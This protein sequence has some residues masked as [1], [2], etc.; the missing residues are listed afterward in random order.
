MQEFIRVYWPLA[1]ITLL[2]VL[3]ALMFVDPGPPRRVA[4]AGGASGGAYAGAAAGYAAALEDK[5]IEAEV[6]TTAGS[7]E[8]LRRLAAGEADIAVVQTGTAEGADTAALRSIGAVFYEPLWVFHRASLSPDDLEDLRGRRVAVGV[9]GS[10]QR[11]LADRLL[12]EEGLGPADYT[13]V[14]LGGAAAAA[15]LK[16]GEIDAALIVS[17]AEPPWIADLVAAPGVELMSMTAAPGLARRNPFL[18]E[19]MLYEGVLD[20]ARDL[21]RRDTT[22]L[23]PA[24]EIVVRA[25]LHPA[26]QS[27]LIEAAYQ[28]HARGTMLAEAGTFPTPDLTDIPLSGE[29]QRYYRNGP[30]F[31]RRYFPYDIA[32]FL[33]RAWVLAIPLVTLMFPLA[34]V[35]PPVYRWRIRRRI[36]IWYRDLRRLEAEGR[37]ARSPEERAAV[38]AKLR[39]LQAEAGEV[40]VPLSYTDNLFHL[41]QHIKFVTD[42]MERLSAQDASAP[43]KPAAQTAAA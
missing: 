5:G 14:E 28:V 43:A 35:A 22:L 36:Y 33:E 6:L 30:T 21:P 42:L 10:G 4:I 9:D 39:E 37:A 23:A 26:V 16:A 31:L 3:A 27:L 18:A 41:R 12:A 34:K 13:P 32:N 7:V 38:C 24:A 25:G 2:G 15:A 17:G 29:A 8:N 40:V 1:V 19:V 11:Q 20:P